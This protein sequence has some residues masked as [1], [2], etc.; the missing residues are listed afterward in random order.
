MGK[1]SLYPPKYGDFFSKLSGTVRFE[2]SPALKFTLTCF[3]LRQYMLK[4]VCGEKCGDLLMFVKVGGV[5]DAML[6]IIPY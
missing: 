5:R 6:Y 3:L 2:K 4:T 1:G